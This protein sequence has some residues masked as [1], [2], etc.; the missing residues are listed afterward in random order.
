MNYSTPTTTN[1]APVG[2]TFYFLIGAIF[3]LAS[4]YL[5]L[6]L[7][8]YWDSSSQQLIPH[9]V[10]LLGSFLN[11]VLAL[12]L[13]FIVKTGDPRAGVLKTGLFWRY[14]LYAAVASLIVIC[15]VATPQPRGLFRALMVIAFSLHLLAMSSQFFYRWLVKFAGKGIGR[16][17][18]LTCFNCVLL[19]LLLE[20]G[21]RLAAALTNSPLL[22]APNLKAAKR[23]SDHKLTPG[24]L[25]L[26]FAANRQG[27]F[28]REFTRTKPNNT[29][30]ILGL[31]DSF[32]V[33]G[34]SYQDNFLTLLET[35][36]ADASNQ[37]QSYE[38]M[39]LSV[40][41]ISPRGYLNLLKEY[42][43][44]YQADLALVCI[45][46]GN[47]IGWLPQ[48][49]PSLAYLRREFWYSYFVPA[50]IV[51]L[52]QEH[53]RKAA[54]TLIPPEG[55]ISDTPNNSVAETLPTFS[56]EAFLQIERKRLPVCLKPEYAGEIN[57]RYQELYE[58]LDE[59]QQPTAGNLLVVLI[60][61]E[62]QVDDELWE[63]LT[64]NNYNQYDR[65]RPQREISAFCES[66]G[67]KS[68]DLL[69]A[70]SAEDPPDTYLLQDT[71]WNRQG[72]LIATRE[73]TAAIADILAD[74]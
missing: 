47:D 17:I 66:A 33:E 15:A 31:A 35:S 14:W 7:S 23:I 36:L 70:L 29:I 10:A 11:A 43:T 48:R 21:L 55:D 62:F 74:K 58:I 34:V 68:L 37:E 30:R 49:Q 20:G 50:R 5:A 53:T 65:T 18:D 2:K 39:N 4:I 9:C 73:I 60:P 25:H 12:R 71:H 3:L 51:A 38:I 45:F 22:S 67:I 40:D 64:A 16:A 1:Q 27:F 6:R 72:H 46:V 24:G 32:G 52:Y 8:R 56:Q 57:Q 59:M 44:P 13:G 54:S 69:P 63:L 19:L 61:D 26:G 28:D 42:Y 41:G